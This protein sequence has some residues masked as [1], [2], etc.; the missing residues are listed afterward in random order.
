M[1]KEDFQTQC[2]KRLSKLVGERIDELRELND[3]MHP[4]EKTAGIRGG[5]SELKKILALADSASAS[6]AANPDHI[7]VGQSLE[8]Q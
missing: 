3:T 6:D 5:I 7:G 2:W 4:I 8:Q 1:L